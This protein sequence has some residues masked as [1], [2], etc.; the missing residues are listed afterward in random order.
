MTSFDDELKFEAALIELL[1]MRY[2]W[3]KEVLVNPTEEQLIANWAKILLKI[4]EV[5]TVWVNTH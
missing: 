5:S 1:H 3:E 4:T 2:G